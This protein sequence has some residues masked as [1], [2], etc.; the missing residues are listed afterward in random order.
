M[1]F[2]TRILTPVFHGESKYIAIGIVMVKIPFTML[3]ALI[4][5]VRSLF[6]KIIIRT[7]CNNPPQKASSRRILFASA[8]VMS[9]AALL[10]AIGLNTSNQP[11]CVIS[12]LTFISA[13]SLG[14]GPVTWIV[15]GEVMPTH[16]AT[17][18]GAI[19]LAMNWSTNFCVSAAF[20]PLQQA[21]E[22]GNRGNGNVFFLISG[23]C[24]AALLGTWWSY[25]RRERVV[26][27]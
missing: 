18:A 16:A 24:F 1:Y 19:G 22:R 25:S 23:T 26:S 20:L 10:L 11:L 7:D 9:I 8:A 2:S 17:V 21:M 3:S 27:A 12:V 4:V 13:F 5:R 6:L 14:L 15:L